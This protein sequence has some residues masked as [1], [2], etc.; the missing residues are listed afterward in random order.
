MSPVKD[1]QFHMIGP[2][3]THLQTR[4]RQKGSICNC[5]RIYVLRVADGTSIDG[6]FDD[7]QCPAFPNVPFCHDRLEQY[8]ESER[9]VIYKAMEQFVGQQLHTAHSR[10]QFTPPSR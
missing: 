8:S 5:P 10:L 7:G 3:L 1:T 9:Q 4:H 6:T 2:S